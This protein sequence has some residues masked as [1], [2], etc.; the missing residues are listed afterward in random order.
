[1][2]KEKNKGSFIKGTMV[3]FAIIKSFFLSITQVAWGLVS[4]FGL[5]WLITYLMV[6]RQVD[7]S[8]INLLFI[9]MEGFIVDNIMWFV[10]AFFILYL[11]SEIKEVLK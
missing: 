10:L 4:I 2:E 7:L 8:S 11:Y 1:M 3:V 6:N 5:N 9:Q